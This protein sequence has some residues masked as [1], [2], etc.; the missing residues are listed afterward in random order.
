MVHMQIPYISAPM[1]LTLLRSFVTV[2]EAGAITD[3]AARI[4]ITQPALSRR[5]QAL[6]EH[7]GA[8]LLERGRNGVRVTEAGRLV[9][10]EAQALIARFDRLRET[11]GAHAR[12]EVGTVRVGGGATAVSFLVPPA[13][14]AVQEDHEQIRFQVKEAGSREIEADVAAENLELGIVTLPVTGSDLEVAPLFL[15]EIV[16]VAAATHPLSK[17]RRIAI[18]RLGNFG[19]V[20]F[21]GGSAIRQIID[22]QL[23]N[24]GVEPNVVMELRSIPAILRMVATTGNLAFVSRLGVEADPSV[25]VLDVRR[26]SIVRQL[27]VITRRGRTL[28]P[29][30]DA[31]L[32]RL[33]TFARNL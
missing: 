5:V 26:L 1:D 2:A 30:A 25:A 23:R 16:P 12:L 27:G 11:V 22:R 19:L 7:F 10:I 3:A 29:A 14:A 33:R 20:G 24:A 28:S 4:N 9:L 21:E 18:A 15:D 32:L 13:I 17:E 6:E 8:P 31:F